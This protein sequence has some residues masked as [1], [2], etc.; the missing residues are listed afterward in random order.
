MPYNKFKI[1]HLQSKLMLPVKKADWLHQTPAP[2]RED[3]MLIRLL[4]EAKN[5]YL[6]S[7][8]ARS[9]FIV[10][11]ILQALHRQNRTKF[12]IFSG[13][14]FNIDK[15]NGLNGFC[16]FILS[17]PANGFL[18]EAPA[19]FVVETKKADI[20]DNAIAQCGAEMYAAQIFNER[21]GK[22]I[23]A[24]YGCVTSA[25]SWGFLKLENNVLLIDPNYVSLS[26]HNPYPV[27][28]ALQWVLGESF[29]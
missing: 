17:S 7:E 29:Q 11:P 13:Y 14:E 19:L 26:F 1:D 2:F 24:V 8:K 25:Y 10:T 15:A 9:E 20:D 6:G 18:V 16:D 22:P 21:K 28:A 5:I 3:A 4:G 23:H 12:S 27:L